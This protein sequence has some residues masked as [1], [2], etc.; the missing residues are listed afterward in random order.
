MICVYDS[1]AGVILMMVQPVHVGPKRIR[2]TTPPHNAHKSMQNSIGFRG[3]CMLK[4][5]VEWHLW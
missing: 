1:M 3:E 2:G 4:G 5:V